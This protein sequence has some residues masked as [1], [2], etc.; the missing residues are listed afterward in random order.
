MYDASLQEYYNQIDLTGLVVLENFVTEEEE[1][2]LVEEIQTREWTMSQS[3]RYK[4]DYGLTKVNFKKRKAK[5][6]PEQLT[7]IP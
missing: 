1:K 4:L 6:K 2:E 7:K 3:G 5:T